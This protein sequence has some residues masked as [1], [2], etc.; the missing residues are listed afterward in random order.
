MEGAESVAGKGISRVGRHR[1]QR[2]D[3]AIV[4]AARELLTEKGYRALTADAVAERAHIGK[5]AIYRRYRTKQQMVFAATVPGLAAEPPSDTGSLR[6]DLHAFTD[7]LVAGLADPTSRATL[8]GLVGELHND[9]TLAGWFRTTFVAK[10]QAGIGELLD[11]A[12]R[13]GELH[14]RPDP[15]LINALLIGPIFSWLLLQREVDAE[16]F[17]ARLA[18]L[19]TDT[20]ILAWPEET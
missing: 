6:G 16:Q 8:A 11:R 18:S 20:L 3:H 13:R 19:L 9:E 15:E 14:A 7:L 2:V 10:A 1:E 17:G 12:I 5:A 4:R